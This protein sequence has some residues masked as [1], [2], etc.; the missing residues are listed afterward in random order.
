MLCLYSFGLSAQKNF[1][2]ISCWGDS[3]TQGGQESK[4]ISYP[5]ILQTLL[6][7]AGYTIPVYNF[8]AHG[9]KSTEIMQRQGALSL[10]IQPFTIP[11]SAKEETKVSINS[12]LRVPEAGCN[13]CFVADIEGYLRHDWTDNNQQ[14]FYFHRSKDGIAVNIEKPT[15]IIT[16]A[17]LYHRNDVLVMDIGYNGGYSSVQD[18]IDQYKKMVDFSNCKEFIVIGRASHHYTT[19]TYIEKA[20][21]EAFGDRYISL[22]NYYVEHGLI[23]AGIEATTKDLV[24]IATQRP[25]SS[26][27]YDEHHENNAGYAIKAKL[28]FNKLKELGI[29]TSS[30][31]SII[32]V[33]TTNPPHGIYSLQ[34]KKISKINKS[35]IYIIDGEKR[36]IKI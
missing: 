36:Y 32:E 31:A 18:W 14:T 2:G 16:D 7:S 12:R 4:D 35:G 10:I 8:G 24:D 27:F 23:D 9:E 11:A 28:V 26:L 6:D 25:P 5:S 1:D 33:R 13:P 20:F 22:S 3:K 29:I 15:R 34:G 17:M 21:N 19:D 30:P